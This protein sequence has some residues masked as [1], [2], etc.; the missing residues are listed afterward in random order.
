MT[1]A[2]SLHSANVPQHL[3]ATSEIGAS[4]SIETVQ[5][6]V[7]VTTKVVFLI[8]A[9][10]FFACLPSASAFSV[11]GTSRTTLWQPRHSALSM[12]S[13]MESGPGYTVSASTRSK[14][15]T[16]IG[17]PSLAKRRKDK[18]DMEEQQEQ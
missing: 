15:V 8:S 11:A 12:S 2:N 10:L 13:V 1:Q 3:E 6:S 7:N 5:R 14:T 16:E 9:T 17:Y 4:I 18:E